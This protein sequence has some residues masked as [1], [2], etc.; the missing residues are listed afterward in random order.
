MSKLL[1]DRRA[2]IVA[3]ASTTLLAA[4]GGNLIGPP[5]ASP[6]YMLRPKIPPTTTGVPVNWQIS[7]ILPE[8]P[9]S[10]DSDRIALVQPNGQMDYYANAAWQDRVPFLVQTALIEAFEANTRIRAVGRDTDGLR[11]DYFLQTDIRDFQARYDVPDGIPTAVV[12]FSV[13]LIQARGRVITQI[14]IAHS[15]VAATANSVPAV[16][17]A[18]NQALSDALGQVVGWA[19]DAPKPP[20][21]PA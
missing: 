1:L 11:S 13:K 10:L 2:F 21:P 9:Q 18:F 6:L 8:A 3:G 20:P 7:I 12:R 14:M 19:L 16:A 17:A 5:D 4:C 15:E